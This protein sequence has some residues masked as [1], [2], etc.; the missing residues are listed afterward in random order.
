M[1]FLKELFKSKERKS[2]KNKHFVKVEP[3]LNRTDKLPSD[4]SLLIVDDSE[5]IREILCKYFSSINIKVDVASNGKEGFDKFMSAPDEYDVVLLDI[6]MPVM[7]G[8]ET[9]ISIRTS[10]TST[11]KSIIIIVMTGNMMD[12]VPELY[13]GY[14]MKPFNPESMARY[15]QR[16]L[17]EKTLRDHLL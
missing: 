13:D 3:F 10:D 8:K 12:D 2:E 14:M 4:L 15:V 1:S 7:N 6:E 17:S 9:L 16:V 5:E 11:A